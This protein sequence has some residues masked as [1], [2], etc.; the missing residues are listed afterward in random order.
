MVPTPGM[1]ARLE[2]KGFEDVRLWS[3]GVDTELFTPHR[4]IE[5]DLPRPIWVYTGRVA[6][7]KNLKAFLQLD[8]PGS[9]MI[10]GNGPDL[11][12]LQATF[13]DVYFAGYRFGKELADYMAGCDVFVFPS[14]TDT[15]G[16][17]MLEAMACGLPIAAYPV[18]GPIDVVAHHVSGILNED[19]ETACM[20]AL[21]LDRKRCRDVALDHSWQRCTEQFA[22]LL[23]SN[24]PSAKNRNL[25]LVKSGVFFF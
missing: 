9:K 15:F 18:T 23:R 19:L 6:V 8:L 13:P 10:I 4:A 1:Q 3:R 20:Q 24:A 2:R 5:H 16:I 14:R 17:V 25:T 11:K 21:R 22:S 12:R 7:E